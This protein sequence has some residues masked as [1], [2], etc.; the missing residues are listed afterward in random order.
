MA[1]ITVVDD[2]DNLLCYK[3][4]HE[5]LAGELF[6]CAAAWITDGNGNI[7]LQRRALSK[8]T[9][10][11]RWSAAVTGHVDEGETYRDAIIRE[12]REELGIVI[13]PVEFRKFFRKDRD[14]FFSM[15]FTAVVPRD[16]VLTV[17]QEEVAEVKWWAREELILRIE[18][19]PDEFVPSASQWSEY[20]WS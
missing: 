8:E 12:A 9:N 19:H 2:A 3:E 15:W 20:F 10:P 5:L 1:R 4:K 13:N 14:E 17:D 6:R 18:E 7:L 11:G 16:I